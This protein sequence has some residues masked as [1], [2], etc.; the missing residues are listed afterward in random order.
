MFEGKVA[1][2][3]GRVDRKEGDNGGGGISQ[4]D[5]MECLGRHIGL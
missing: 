2:E 5:M 4:M 1:G 3:V